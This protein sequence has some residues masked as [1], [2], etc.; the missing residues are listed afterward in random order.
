M[1]KTITI[2]LTLFTIYESNC[3]VNLIDKEFV[4]SNKIKSLTLYNIDILNEES[5]MFNN[6]SIKES[7]TYFFDN[8]GFIISLIK[9]KTSQ[10][11]TLLYQET[12]F[13]YNNDD[14]FLSL[15]KSCV[16]RSSSDGYDLDSGNFD[17]IDGISFK[18]NQ[19]DSTL[20]CTYRNYIADEDLSLY[21]NYIYFDRTPLKNGLILYKREMEWLKSVS[22][23]YHIDS[24]IKDNIMNEIFIVYSFTSDESYEDKDEDTG[25]EKIYYL[26]GLYS[27]QEADYFEENK[28]VEKEIIRMEKQGFDISL[29]NKKTEKSILENS[30][31]QIKMPDK[32]LEI[33]WK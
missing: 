23:I 20:K 26:K 1:R 24:T 9:I 12:K 29:P 16:N 32:I 13:I 11:D 8:Y 4:K 2:I 17:T 25:E 5:E 27:Y 15:T 7:H 18:I 3:Q 28:C 19:I 21:F 6:D 33:R 22:D 30:I 14:L 31:V 10:S